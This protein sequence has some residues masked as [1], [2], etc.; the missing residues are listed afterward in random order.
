MRSTNTH[1]SRE[2][3]LRA[4]TAALRPL[5]NHLGSPLPDKI[6]FAIAFPSAGGRGKAIGECWDASAS[7]DQ[8][9]EIFIR[10][11]RSEPVDVLGILVHELV[12]AA[13]PV[14]A[15]HGKLFRALALKL[16]LDG[17][18]RHTVPGP[19]LQ[20][21]LTALAEEL[22]SLPHARLEIDR[23]TAD[24]GPD[25]SSPRGPVD[26]PKKQGTR[27]L[28]A[29]CVADGCG[30]TVRLAAKWAR[31]VGPPHCPSHGAMQVDPTGARPARHAHGGGATKPVCRCCLGDVGVP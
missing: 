20:R 15:G 27:L 17:P 7:A 18:M 8:H 4:A 16:G 5:F 25:G 30:Y 21:H 24:P 12:H 10:A 14:D 19:M 26:R 2:A 1:D 29:T 23:R 9:V 28:K 22:G 11:D 3:W 6:R 13:L 31:E